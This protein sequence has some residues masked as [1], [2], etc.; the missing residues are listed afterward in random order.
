MEPSPPVEAREALIRQLRFYF[1]DANLRRDK[2]LQSKVGADG[3]EWMDVGVLAS[4]NRVAA[5]TRDA[6]EISAALTEVAEVELSPDGARVRRLEPVAL[7]SREVTEART[8]YVEN[9]PHGMGQSQLEQLLSSAV[10]PVTYV[11]LPR[12]EWPEARPSKGYAFVEFVH[13]RDA[14]R[15]TTMSVDAAPRRTEQHGAEPPPARLLRVMLKRE[16]LALRE[17][18]ARRVSAQ[19]EWASSQRDRAAAAQQQPGDGRRARLGAQGGAGSPGSAQQPPAAAGAAAAAEHRGFLVRVER[20][21][22][23]A[24]RPALVQA[25]QH[26]CARAAAGAAAQGLAAEHPQPPMACAP[27]AAPHAPAAAPS[28]GVAAAEYVD[29]PKPAEPNVAY[30]RFLTAAD[31]SACARA[32]RGAQIAVEGP[33]REAAAGESTTELGL[34][35]EL[36]GAE[37]TAEYWRKVNLERAQRWLALQRKR[38]LQPAAEEHA[39]ER[40]STTR[41]RGTGARGGQGGHSRGVA[42]RGRG[43]GGRGRGST[44]ARPA[45]SYTRFDE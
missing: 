16:W 38:G 1:S 44:P 25:I 12:F 3:R 30:A 19:L 45:G 11:A 40:Q 10:G 21:P 41:G 9:L 42:A 17:E 39:G 7:A 29:F 18:Y 4:F 13:E 2:F 37:A 35:A 6:G 24:S 23:H 32:L 15:A 43:E 33:A 20:V 14:V 31:A 34:G 5:M 36:L 27:A 26:A 8:V 22:P 28:A